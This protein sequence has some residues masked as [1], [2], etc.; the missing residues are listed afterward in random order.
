M[1][2]RPPSLCRGARGQE[3]RR[4]RVL[5]HQPAVC[6][7]VVERPDDAF[8]NGQL[9]FPAQ[10]SN[11]RRVEKDEGAVAYPAAVTAGVDSHRIDPKVPTD[12]TDGVV[13]LAVFVGAQVEDVDLVL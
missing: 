10:R 5:A 7:E 11:S 12:P 1:P 9:R 4:S 8:P 3:R 13:D 6:P 2:G